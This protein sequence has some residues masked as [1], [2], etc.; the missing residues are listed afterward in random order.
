MEV[1]WRL[2]AAHWGRGYAPEGA[3]AALRFGFENLG[4]DDVVSF[5]SVGNAKSRRVMT[6]I[7]MTHRPDED[8]DHP[9][10]LKTSPLLRHVL[11][12]ITAAAFSGSDVPGEQHPQP[13]Q[14]HYP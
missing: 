8:F 1:G 7:G 13:R 3:R 11:Y 14:R 4:L 6:K 12:R 10:L 2:A 9:R 5:T